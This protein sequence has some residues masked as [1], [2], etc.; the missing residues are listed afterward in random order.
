MTKETETMTFHN[1]GAITRI[2]LWANIIGYTILVFAL[3]S[4]SYQASNLIK[5]W[6]QV[7]QGFS[8]NP[9]EVIAALAGQVFM[10]PLI[11]VFYFLVLRGLS[12]L[13]NLG[14][15]LYYGDAEMVDLEEEAA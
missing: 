1:E 11:G 12:Q 5:N 10:D 14:L 7:M 2:S 6:S 13:L 3:I 4:F 15:D 8:V 9:F